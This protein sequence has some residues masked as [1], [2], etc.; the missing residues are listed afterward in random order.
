MGLPVVT[1]AIPP[2]DTIVR[3]GQE[4]LL[5][6]EGDQAGLT[7]A[8]AA[9]ASDPA[10]RAALGAAARARVV[11]HYSWDAHCAQ[12]ERALEAIR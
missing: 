8:I 12:L 1:P 3:A 10:R 11:A 4:G 2:L 7:T 9:L 6:P 5:Y